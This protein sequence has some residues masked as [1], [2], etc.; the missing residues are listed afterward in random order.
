MAKSKIEKEL[1]MER[2]NAS[3]LMDDAEIKKAED[4]CKGYME[5]MAAAKTEREINIFAIEKAKKA[6]FKEFHFGDK[7]KAGDKIYYDNRGKSVIMAVIGSEPIANGVNLTAAHIDSPRLDL[8]QI[9][10]YETDEL[11]YFRTHYYGGIK[12]YQW[13]TIPLELHG[14]VALKSGELVD[15]RIGREPGDP[16]FV[17]T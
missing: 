5:F 9:P 3:L 2:K 6:G 17:I 16:R 10:M 11:C 15:V 14:V 13:V 12:K 8:K 1:T 4:F 7:L